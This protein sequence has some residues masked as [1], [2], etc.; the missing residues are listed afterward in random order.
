MKKQLLL[1][2]LLLCA[3][4]QA[5]ADEGSS[6]I[7]GM[8]WR[9]TFNG[10]AAED[11]QPGWGNPSGV[12][13]IPDRL[14]TSDA[15]GYA[16][17]T[18]TSICQFAFYYGTAMTGVIIPSTVTSIGMYAFSTCSNLTSVYCYGETPPTITSDV[19][20]TYD[21]AT[22]YVP[23]GS[24]EDYQNADVWKNFSH[25]EPVIF[26]TTID[27]I[28]YSLSNL[29]GEA[30]VVW[31]SSY[32]AL[33]TL[34]IPGTVE[35]NGQTWPVTAIGESVFYRL[36]NL[37]SVTIP[38]SV[39]TIGAYAFSGC[40]GMTSLTLSEGLKTIG[41]YAFQDCSGLTSVTI[42]SGVEYMYEG[43]FEN[44]SGLTSV[45]IPAS[46]RDIYSNSFSH[47]T[48]LT[49]VSFSEG[50]EGIG[51]FAFYDCSNLTSVTLPSSVMG[52]GDYAFDGCS[53]LTS[54]YC[55]AVT[56][57]TITS[58]TFSNYDVTLYVSS[59]SQEAY[60]NDEVW[61]NFTRIEP[62]FDTTWT[63]SNGMTWSFTVRGTEATD[64]KPAMFEN[65][66]VYGGPNHP[67]QQPVT[68]EPWDSTDGRFNDLEGDN[69]PTLSDGVYFGHK[70]LI[71]DIVAI[72]GNP[73]MRVMNGW[74]SA[75]YA[76]NVP[77][78]VDLWEL[79]IT[80]AIANDCAQGG[81]GRDLVIMML[82]G[83]I[84]IKS[85]YYEAPSVPD[86]VVIPAKVY[87]GSTELTVTSIGDGAFAD[88]SNMTSVTI[89]SSV[90]SIGDF[91]FSGCSGLTGVS[92][93]SNVASIGKSAFSGSGLTSVNIPSRVASI[94]DRVFSGCT[95]LTN[96]IIPSSVTNIGERAFEDCTALTSVTLPS[97]VKS[98][99][100]RA[101][102]RC[103][104]TS[105]NFPDGLMSIGESAFSRC[106]GLTSV[107]IPSSVTS[108]GQA[109]FSSNNLTSIKVNSGNT[110]YDSRGNCN[111]IIEK[112]TNTLMVGC[113]NTVIP[114]N[115]TSIA[116]SAFFE[117]DLT[118][119]TIPEGVTSIG[120]NA[121]RLC[122]NLTS[123]TI[124]STVTSIGS[125]AFYGCSGLMRVYC[126][127]E[128][129][130][131]IFSDDF[132]T[133]DTTT[134]Y[135]PEASLEEYL[136]AKVWR[137]FTNIE[138]IP[139]LQYCYYADTGE[140]AVIRGNYSSM[141]TVTIP[142]QVTYEGVTYT[143]T[144]IK[145]AAFESCHSLTSVTLPSTLKVIGERAF[146]DCYNLESID[147]PEGLTTIEQ[148]AFQDCY[149]LESIDLP[150]NLTTIGNYAFSDSPLTSVT[151]NMANPPS[152]DENV[153][154]CYNTATLYVPEN[155]IQAY[156][157][158][159]TWKKFTQIEPI[160]N[161]ATID[162]LK[163]S[164]NQATG[165]ATVIKGDYSALTTV[166]IPET[167]DHN[168]V[169]Y[170]VTAIGETAFV[171]CF[172]LASV[173]LPESVTTIGQGA[174]GGCQSLTNLT[175]P[176]NLT[177]IG[178]SAFEHS[179]LTSVVIPASTTSIDEQ[180]FTWC[181]GLT[182]ISVANGNPVYDSRND[183]NAII[184]TGTGTLI[185]GCQNTT[186]PEG[187]TYIGNYSFLGCSSLTHIIIPEGV[188][189]IGWLAFYECTGLTSVSF[190]ASVTGISSGAF[191]NCSAL[192]SISVADGN[193]VYDS[194]NDCNAVIETPTN[195][196][197]LGCKNTI[198][199]QD[200]T[201]IGGNAFQG[202]TGLTSVNIP[203]SVTSM[204]NSPFSGCSGLTSVYCDAA[205]PAQIN[206]S[207]FSTYDTTT[208]YVPKGSLQAY[209]NDEKWG[210]FETIMEF[211]LIPGD[212]NAD[213]KVNVGDF[214]ATGSFILGRTIS[215][216]IFKDADI[217]GDG[218]I[219]VGDFISIGSI[220]LR[221]SP[222][223]GAN[224]GAMT[225]PRRVEEVTP[226]EIEPE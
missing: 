200:V 106:S 48:S 199:P 178:N 189:I 82:E 209:R 188:E 49:S 119:V 21:T 41:A 69:F 210:Q 67:D 102:Y 99:G 9:C 16:E 37:E 61:Q 196:L 140:A 56:P 128:T 58:T 125:Q 107:I 122:S 222:T 201:S 175:L 168:G 44:C 85:V 163:Y 11:V 212:V 47:C 123:V 215:P 27:G 226:T 51:G 207:T 169:T 197:I 76:D 62:V 92:I 160:V 132:S 219:N 151:C 130:P 17:Y 133:Y 22:L 79:P 70:T 46:V 104:L 185:T 159:N 35:C 154:S 29:T 6:V 165:E 31:S 1:W 116:Y 66:Y 166:T 126:Y 149:G 25:I 191:H 115:V 152:I 8:L 139:E 198:I 117:C 221:N 75:T 121:F 90:T 124:P 84:T 55:D 7:D 23:E 100:E 184:K 118:S 174:F 109:A 5:R 225:A 105:V 157:E 60:Q 42:P 86:V 68:L 39:T 194:R 150:A 182:S 87:V 147:L 13:E 214:I 171:A 205:T 180:A 14:Y 95:G 93:P 153:F 127:V 113:K 81:L 177:T 28:D 50:L 63:D 170:D 77:M 65:C 89:P 135:V 211:E 15:S 57:P 36:T 220:I 176:S 10:S 145:I 64:I 190:P 59:G 192:T 172:D 216:F 204:G 98:I 223:S 72:E 97:S 26:E 83:K 19:F 73:K 38:S 162:G 213:T 179:G 45:S 120:S 32:S 134:L 193:T 217:N 136:Y 183:C 138:P 131:T 155:S 167:V 187:V 137:D 33:T 111:A 114:N 74:W 96:V 156:Q 24:L 52:I 94:N 54:V 208:L 129:P 181:P 53:S 20:S 2:V 18:V 71:F 146:S 195:T 40:S 144:A 206:Y 88:C 43:V 142:E 4:M 103:A 164:F 202:C 108:I 148:G 110:V 161:E 30:T 224:S 186:I 3:V 143:V 203:E 101:F 78:S 218:A 80:E 91:A 173:T 34:N 112:A 158:A 12:V 141:E